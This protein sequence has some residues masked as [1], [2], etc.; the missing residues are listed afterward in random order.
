MIKLPE[1]KDEPKHNDELK[2]YAWG[3]NTAIKSAEYWF[4]R[5]GIE[6]VKE[7]F[8]NN[9]K[10]NS[11]KKEPYYKGYYDGLIEI[12]RLN[13]GE[14]KM[15][16]KNREETI[17]QRIRKARVEKGL[18]IQEF[19]DKLGRDYS[20]VVKYEKDIRTPKTELLEKI[21]DILDVS[22]LYLQNGNFSKKTDKYGGVLL[23]YYLKPEEK[24]ARLSNIEKLLKGDQ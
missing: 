7:A 23:T 20:F 18:S 19:A 21:G 17:G 8:S 14:E 16:Q 12:E 10:Y 13:V 15:K 11:K 22:Y 3:W 6:Y 4:N 1:K 9:K 24:D 2:K 5:Y